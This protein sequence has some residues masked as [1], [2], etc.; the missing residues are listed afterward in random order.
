[1]NLLYPIFIVW[2]SDPTWKSSKN[3][4]FRTRYRGFFFRIAYMYSF[5]IIS[6]H[7]ISFHVIS[8]HFM[9]FHV[10]HSFI[11]SFLHSKGPVLNKNKLYLLHVLL[12]YLNSH[13]YVCHFLS[14]RNVLI[15][16][17]NLTWNHKMTI[18]QITYTFHCKWKTNGCCRVIA[19]LENDHV[20]FRHVWTIIKDPETSKYLLRVCFRIIFSVFW[21]FKGYLLR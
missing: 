3:L 1:M 10:I 7:F 18:N 6:Y 2:E 19:I 21:R 14:A 4:D 9:S 8:C 11:H 16:P 15:T 13:S 20:V 12:Q 5:H 17:W